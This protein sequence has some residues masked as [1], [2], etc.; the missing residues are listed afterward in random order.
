[1]GTWSGALASTKLAAVR[2]LASGLLVL[3]MPPNT[4]A[5]R[6]PSHHQIAKPSLPSLL[7]RCRHHHHLHLPPLSPLPCHQ[8]VTPPRP[9]LPPLFHHIRLHPFT[10]YLAA[11]SCASS[12][13]ASSFP[14]VAVSVVAA[15][16]AVGAACLLVLSLWWWLRCCSFPA[17][18]MHA[19]SLPH[20]ASR[21]CPRP[22]HAHAEQCIMDPP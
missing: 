6:H 16:A 8:H 13:H 15:A 7:L 2:C 20:G 4:S 14:F 22:T 17:D 5:A 10:L 11:G 21:I 1:M 9:S 12:L 3:C 18:Q 19:T